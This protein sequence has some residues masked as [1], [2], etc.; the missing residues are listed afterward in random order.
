MRMPAW[1]TS[2]EILFS[3]LA[4]L[5]S[6]QGRGKGAKYDFCRTRLRSCPR[7][8]KSE[9]GSQ[10]SKVRNQKSKIRIKVPTLSQKTRQGWG[11]RIVLVGFGDDFH[12]FFCFV[13]VDDH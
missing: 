2:N 4:R 5:A 8:Q 11:T 7:S 13:D 9:G 3:A 1:I 6:R 10:K 12:T